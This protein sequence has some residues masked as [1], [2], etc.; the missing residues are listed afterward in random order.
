MVEERC[1]DED[2]VRAPEPAVLDAIEDDEAGVLREDAAGVVLDDVDEGV[3]L[4]G[5]LPGVVSGVLS[6]APVVVVSKVS[7]TAGACA[8]ATDPTS[9]NTSAKDHTRITPPPFRRAL[10]APPD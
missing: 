8:Y 2:V 7:F 1:D 10:R 5:E 9:V 3:V 6:G 4:A